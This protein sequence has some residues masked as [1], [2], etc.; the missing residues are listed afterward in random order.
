M[1]LSSTGE[2]LPQLEKKFLQQSLPATN[3][4]EAW[5]LLCFSQFA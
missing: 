4:N 5:S 3:Q 2:S 1:I